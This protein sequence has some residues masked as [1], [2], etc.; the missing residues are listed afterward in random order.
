MALIYSFKVAQ[1][2]RLLD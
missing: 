1:H 2:L